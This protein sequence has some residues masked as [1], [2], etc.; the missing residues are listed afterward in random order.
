MQG[1]LLDGAKISVDNG[2]GKETLRTQWMQNIK[3]ATR[4][5]AKMKR[6]GVN[7]IGSENNPNEHLLTTAYINVEWSESKWYE[8]TIK[9]LKNFLPI[10]QVVYNTG[11]QR[12][13]LDEYGNEVVLYT[14]AD[15]NVVLWASY[16][17]G[18][19]LQPYTEKLS[20]QYR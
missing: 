5:W 9:A 1:H 7:V 4:V 13:M 16:L 15:V 2:I 8:E 12:T 18:L 3:L 19:Q 17:S 10:D 11:V 20:I 6:Y 14:G